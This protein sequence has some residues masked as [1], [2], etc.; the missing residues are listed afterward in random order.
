MLQKLSP[1]SARSTYVVSRSPARYG[2]MI[3][4]VLKGKGRRQHYI[5]SSISQFGGFINDLPGTSRFSIGGVCGVGL[6]SVV[7]SANSYSG[8]WTSCIVWYG[9]L[10]S[11]RNFQSPR[12]FYG[13][14][15]RCRSLV[16]LL[17]IAGDDRHLELASTSPRAARYDYGSDA[18]DCT[19]EPAL[20]A[21]RKMT[22]LDSSLG[23]SMVRGGRDEQGDAYVEA[24]GQNHCAAS[25]GNRS[26][27]QAKRRVV[28]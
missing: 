11:P 18:R 19:L 15:T 28:D 27:H 21:L 6:C 23:C 12:T 25:S 24:V 17:Y 8:C 16:L 4:L 5:S 7:E 10:P 26:S 1:R 9:A 20:P 22:C 3:T 13:G 14:R 2:T